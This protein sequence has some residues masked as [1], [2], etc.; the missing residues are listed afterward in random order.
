VNHAD[1]LRQIA[2]TGDVTLWPLLCDD[3]RAAADHI[4]AL[5]AML[6]RFEPIT[7]PFHPAYG[8]YDKRSEVGAS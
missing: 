7:D 5:E 6:A 4:E 8:F 2:D 3:L 1:R